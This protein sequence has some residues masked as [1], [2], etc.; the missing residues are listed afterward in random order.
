MST[1]S[2]HVSDPSI[3]C[4]RELSLL[5]LLQREYTSEIARKVLVPLMTQTS[6]ISLRALDWA[7]V[8]WSKQHNV[9]CTS[10]I[11]G[12]MTN[13]HH[14]YRGALKYWKRRLF[15]PFRRRSRM[16]IVIDGMEFETTLGQANFALWTYKT[17]VLNYVTTNIDVIES[18]MNRVSQRQKQMRRDAKQNGKLYKRRELTQRNTSIC[19]AYRAPQY[20]RFSR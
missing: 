3:L 10:I 12:M 19:I 13:I 6:P 15:D 8:N 5:H 1:V 20:I 4:G 16:T 9:V 18:D 7:V 2:F 17:G 11:P 14:S